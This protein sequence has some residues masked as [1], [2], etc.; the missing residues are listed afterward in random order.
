VQAAVATPAVKAARVA[1]R[2]TQRGPENL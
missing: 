2:A 1:A